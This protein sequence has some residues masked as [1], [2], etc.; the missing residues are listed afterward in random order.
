MNFRFLKSANILLGVPEHMARTGPLVKG[1]P[2]KGGCV[3]TVSA[4]VFMVVRPLALPA[5]F[6][7]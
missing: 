1:S 5:C 3:A 7:A 4:S 6:T 2:G